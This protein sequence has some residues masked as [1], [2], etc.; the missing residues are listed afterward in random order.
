[1]RRVG[2]GGTQVGPVKCGAWGRA[3]S[4]ADRTL[5]RPGAQIAHC[6][7]LT[8]GL[9]C[10]FTGKSGVTGANAGKGDQLREE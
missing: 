9:T 5:H 3:P 4:W 8:C 7:W 2:L 10:V 1:M 6:T